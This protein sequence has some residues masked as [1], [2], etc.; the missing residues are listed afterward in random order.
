MPSTMK[1][2]FPLQI[3][4]S[5]IFPVLLLLVGGILGGIGY[6]DG[7]FFMLRWNGS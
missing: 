6:A 7:S 5:T 4:I 3:H 2:R 1:C